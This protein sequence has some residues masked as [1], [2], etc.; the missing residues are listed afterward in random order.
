M[1]N[2][3]NRENYCRLTAMIPKEIGEQFKKK[4]KEENISMNSIFLE[5]VEKFLGNE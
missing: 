4:C 5:A 2:R 1:K 3:W